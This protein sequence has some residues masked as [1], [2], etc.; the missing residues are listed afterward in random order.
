[1]VGNLTNIVYTVRSNIFLTYDAL[2][3]LTTMVDGVGTTRYSYDNVGQLLSEDGPWNDDTVSYIYA[4]RLRTSLSLQ[5]PN[6]DSWAESY[7]FD[8]AK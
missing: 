4:N 5:A 7:G 8:T 3:R 6:A 2:N 1:M